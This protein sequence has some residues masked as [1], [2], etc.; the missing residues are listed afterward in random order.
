MEEVSDCGVAIRL[1]DRHRAVT[2]GQSAAIYSE[3]T[4]LGGGPILRGERATVPLRR[5]VG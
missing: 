3:D 4:L 2:P 1:F 5:A